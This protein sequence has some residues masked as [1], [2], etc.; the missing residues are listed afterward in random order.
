M[1]LVTLFVLGYRPLAGISCN[2]QRNHL[3]TEVRSYRPLAGIS[4][5]LFDVMTRQG[6]V[7][8]SSPCGDKLQSQNPD[9]ATRED[10]Y[11]PLAGISC[12]VEWAK[13]LG[14]YEV[15]VPLRG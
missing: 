4:C 12:N 9:R 11:R 3:R 6:T 14:I 13:N 1:F 15:I 8:L 10:G 7:E 5:N 2:H